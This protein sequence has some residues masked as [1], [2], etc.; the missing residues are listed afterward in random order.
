MSQ[1]GPTTYKKLR[2]ESL[3]QHVDYLKQLLVISSVRYSEKNNKVCAETVSKFF[4][5]WYIQN[6]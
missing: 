2:N 3:K 1:N 4:L 5:P 6:R